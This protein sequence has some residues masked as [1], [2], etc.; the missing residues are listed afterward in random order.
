MEPGGF[1]T[2][3][4]LWL[5]LCSTSVHSA[6]SLQR[7]EVGFTHLL[8][9]VTKSMQGPYLTHQNNITFNGYKKVVNIIS[10]SG[11]KASFLNVTIL[12]RLGNNKY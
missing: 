5:L 9:Q 12:P 10:L 7:A 2:L 6:G 4:F 11:N 3:S 1:I 8:G